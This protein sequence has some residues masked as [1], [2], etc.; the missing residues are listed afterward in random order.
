[1]RSLWNGLLK[2]PSKILKPPN[3]HVLLE[4]VRVKCQMS[5]VKSYLVGVDEVGRGSWAGPLV[6]AAVMITDRKRFPFDHVKDS[7]R[8]TDAK[9]R[10]LFSLINVSCEIAYGVV[11]NRIIDRS[12]LQYANVLA[13]DCALQHFTQSGAQF[14]ADYIA[15]FNGLTAFPRS[16][17]LHVRG[18]SKFPE[19]AAASIAAKVYRDDL[20][21]RYARNI[22]EYGFDHHKG[23]G[24]RA[25]ILALRRSGRSALHRRTFKF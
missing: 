13:V 1:M 19:I 12:G 9:R 22:P 21:V 17:T 10:R 20:M 24:T 16:V 18:E 23:Y 7:K 2:Q 14:H 3:E 5:K 11:S 4:L 8:L 25:H 15:R 6:A